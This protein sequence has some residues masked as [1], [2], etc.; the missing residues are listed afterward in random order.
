[1]KLVTNCRLVPL[2]TTPSIVIVIVIAVLHP[3]IRVIAVITLL[4]VDVDVDVVSRRS[5][6]FVL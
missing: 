2:L 4:D 3:Y 5:F 6:S 1:M